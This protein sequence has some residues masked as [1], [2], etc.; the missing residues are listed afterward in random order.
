M[1]IQTI[2]GARRER[3]R[4]TNGKR[5]RSCLR[6]RRRETRRIEHRQ[7]HLLL[8]SCTCKTLCCCST[9]NK[10]LTACSFRCT[11]NLERRLCPKPCRS[12]GP[13]LLPYRGSASVCE[14]QIQ[15]LLPCGQI[16]S[17]Q[18]HSIK[19]ELYYYSLT[20]GT[21]ADSHPMLVSLRPMGT[22]NVMSAFMLV[23]PDTLKADYTSQ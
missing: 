21:S 16:L 22:E 10:C 13:V 20:H 7:Q 17:N 9:Q 12:R 5:E 19:S 14:I 2:T 3:C 23:A 8:V 4:C 15:F 6:V 18:R 11:L 1:L